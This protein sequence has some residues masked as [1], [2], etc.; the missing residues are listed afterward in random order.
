LNVLERVSA[1]RDAPRQV[2]FRIAGRLQTSEHAFLDLS[3]CRR[4]VAAW[5]V[6]HHLWP[7]LWL[8]L[9]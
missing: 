4:Q 9:S 8:H 5:F 6:I 3:M 1:T 2:F 7:H